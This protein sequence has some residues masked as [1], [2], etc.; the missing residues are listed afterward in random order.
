MEKITLNETSSKIVKVFE[1]EVEGYK[2]RVN[3]T[4]NAGKIENLNGTLRPATQNEEMYVEGISFRAYKRN[5]Q[6]YTDV[7]GATNAEHD[8]VT[9]VCVALVNQIVAEYEVVAE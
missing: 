8:F 5:N 1:P 9:D 4:V 6:W 7:D 3:L 2:A